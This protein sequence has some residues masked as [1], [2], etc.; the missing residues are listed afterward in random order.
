[1]VFRASDLVVAVVRAKARRAAVAEQTC[2]C[3]ETIRTCQS[4]TKTSPPSTCGPPSG[5]CGGDSCPFLTLAHL[6]I[7]QRRLDLVM[8]EFYAS[9]GVKVKKAS[10]TRGKRAARK[11]K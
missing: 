5:D 3:C 6:K 7:L 9:V 1:M 10:S 11:K 4:C 2:E 8:S